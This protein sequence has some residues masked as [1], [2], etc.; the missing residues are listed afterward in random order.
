MLKTVLKEYPE[1]L[2]KLDEGLILLSHDGKNIGTIDLEHMEIKTSE[3]YKE[4]E[5]KY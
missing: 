2:I 1:S 4:I 5:D 3:K